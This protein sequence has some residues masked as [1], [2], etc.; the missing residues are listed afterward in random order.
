[1]N[2]KEIGELRRRLR[3][4]KNN[5]TAICG[6]FVNSSGEI[7]AC[8][9]DA[10]SMLK[11][12]ETEVYLDRLRKCLSGLQERNLIDIPFTTAQV[13]GSEEHRLLTAMRSASPIFGVQ[14]TGRDLEGLLPMPSWPS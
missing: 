3:L 10:V 13:A 8:I 11:Q 2:Q 14:S 5:I 9:D 7:V 4:D 12:E 6:C 1:M